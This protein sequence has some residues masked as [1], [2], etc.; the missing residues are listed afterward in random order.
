[1]SAEAL[2]R[3]LDTQVI[4]RSITC[5]TACSSTNDHA[6]AMAAQGAP[7][8]A[9]VLAEV[10][11]A[12]RGQR[13]R[14]WLAAPGTCLLLSVLFRPKLRAPEVHLLTMLAACAGAEAVKVVTGLP[15]R[16]KWPN[17][18]MVARRKLGGILVEASLLGDTVEH[19]V[20]GIGLNVNLQ[21]ELYPEIAET[22]TSL[23]REL[24]AGVDRLAVARELLR[25]LDR[26]YLLLRR[27]LGKCL[28][29]EWRGRLDTLGKR[30]ILVD[31]SGNR[32]AVFAEDVA[33][34]GA[35]LVRQ[36][37]GALRS[38]HVGEVSLEEMTGEGP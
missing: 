11:L 37:D 33:P 35:L 3:D 21:V 25:Q 1:M 16:L 9:V 19:V 32:E 23:A 27:G 26:R 5:L 14:A 15:C 38:L 31:S 17:D 6:L 8:G 10:Q 12:G 20:A 4:G 36:A 22:A 2:R 34:D 18:L 13:G 7:D 24:G 29:G 28:C 30:V